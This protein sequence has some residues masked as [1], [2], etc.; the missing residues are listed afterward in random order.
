MNDIVF[1]LFRA[2]LFLSA[3]FG[4]ALV[5]LW[6]TRCRSWFVHRT[7][8]LA[9][10]L[11]GVLAFVPWS[12]TLELPVLASGE[13]LAA[14][15]R[16]AI[17]LESF[18]SNTEEEVV[19]SEW[20][21][22]SESIPVVQTRYSLLSASQ[23]ILAL[24]LAGMVLIPLRQ[25]VRFVRVRY[26]LRDT[27]E[28]CG[29]WSAEWEQLQTENNTDGNGNAA[30]LIPMRISENFG[31]ALIVEP[32][33]LIVPLEGWDNLS[34]P[35]RRSVM[36][37]ELAHYR[38]GD[39]WTSLFARLLALPHWFN[40]FAYL[41]I[42]QYEEAAEW[43]CDEAAL[44]H[45]GESAAVFAKALVSLQESA[46][47]QPILNGAVFQ[48]NIFGQ[49]ISRRVVRL[50]TFNTLNYKESMMK[51]AFLLCVCALLLGSA[52]VQIRLT[53]QQSNNKE[54]KALTSDATAATTEKAEANSS[55]SLTK[56]VIEERLITPLFFELTEKSTYA[57]LFKIIKEYRNIPVFWDTKWIKECGE[58]AI[59][60][61]I[62]GVEPAQY[63][64]MPLGRALELILDAND[65]AYIVDDGFL[66]ITTGERVE[67]MKEQQA[68]KA[69]VAKPAVPETYDPDYVQLLWQRVSTAKFKVENTRTRAEAGT[70]TWTEHEDAKLALAEA[71]YA[72]KQATKVRSNKNPEVPMGM[73]TSPTAGMF[74]PTTMQYEPSGSLERDIFFN[75]AK[76]TALRAK[77]IALD[78]TMN[79]PS[80]IPRSV[81]TQSI[82][83]D[84][85]FQG[86]SHQRDVLKAQREK[87][88]PILVRQDDPRL[89]MYDKEI[90]DLEQQ[91]AESISQEGRMQQ[92][93]TELRTQIERQLWAMD[94]EIRSLEILVAE[95]K[96]VDQK[97][98]SRSNKDPSIPGRDNDKTNP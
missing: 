59:N 87:L 17:E 69:A 2:T 26:L 66:L 65:L 27:S 40:P 44:G 95:L 75:E 64:T 46:N 3:A 50:M 33:T 19:S 14:V 6:A 98:N 32:T 89:K 24:W 29:D 12:R 47:V 21:V 76:L 61:A 72:W 53:A 80:T 93:Q 63:G 48:H 68:E 94:M 88:K 58:T 36:L 28:P 37:H 57:D 23:L 34:P 54:A 91:I 8:W 97:Q 13:S 56:E 73:L 82:Q 10:L 78:E 70:G 49:N 55:A 9:V 5:L 43:A 1:L 92:I 15:P 18:N 90:A 62:A 71:V 86:L 96:E 60:S 45:Q 84:P 39:V 79:R 74:I 77:R 20:R 85:I 25:L 52:F 7:V 38:R 30:K 83:N 51:K 42:R 35:E 22:A 16:T 11:L 4:I 81:L 41:A 31:P 67:K